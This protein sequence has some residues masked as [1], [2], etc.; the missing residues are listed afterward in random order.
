MQRKTL[1][2]FLRYG[3]AAL[4]EI[5]HAQIHEYTLPKRALAACGIGS[6][7]HRRASLRSPE[8]IFLGDAVFIGPENRLW[9][10]P[11]ATL[12]IEDKVL[13]GPNVVI[14]TSN[15]GTSLRDTP[16][17]DQAWE[18]RDVRICNDVWLG[19][20]VVV[21][22]G[23]TIGEHSIIA[24]GAVVTKDVAAYSVMAGVPAR[25]VSTR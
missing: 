6:Y 12:T 18:E 19:A 17:V 5:I 20:N 8:N 11:H 23:V 14:V 9:A 3:P 7:I 10:S 4:L 16:M 2:T 1:W 21:L 22:P 25:L 13:C 15:H 24:A